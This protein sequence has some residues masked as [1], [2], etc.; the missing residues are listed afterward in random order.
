MKK[1]LLLFLFTGIFSNSIV[2]QNNSS[3]D[4]ITTIE[5][6]STII[7]FGKIAKGSD[8]VRSF[9]FK[10]TG[11]YPLKIYQIYSSCNC[12][13]VSKPEEPVAPG[14]TGVIKVKYDT[15]KVGPIV[16]TITGNANL[17]N[18]LFTLRLKGEVLTKSE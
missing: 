8:G 10:N 3:L 5:F 7:D 15:Q 16:K 6:E 17:K 13:I 4:P 12:D 9:I 2:G 14:A 1:L 11:N 18:K